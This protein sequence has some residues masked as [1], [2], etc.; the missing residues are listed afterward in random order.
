LGGVF[1]DHVTW[2]W[3]FYINLPIGAITI[4]GVAI[5]L[6]NPER[7]ENNKSIKT[8]VKELDYYGA[9]FLIP[10]VVCL[11]LALQWGGTKYAWNSATII[12]LFCGFGAIIPIFIYIQIRL[13]ERA[14]IPVRIFLRRSVFF[15]AMYSFFVGSSFLIIVFY[16]PIYFQAVKGS[17]ATKSGI[18][19]LPLLLSVVISSICGGIL[20]TVLGYFTPFMIGGMAIFTVGAGL[21]STLSPDTS[22]GR[23]FGYQVLAGA[24]LGICLQVLPPNY[25]TNISYPS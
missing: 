7:L 14:T 9:A 17:T 6:Q 1:T 5:F 15:S 16:L 20:V 21:L 18:E 4:A 3:C 23:W 24:G 11:L 2:R 19:C 22:F 8:R 10:A 25:H 12:G 13:G